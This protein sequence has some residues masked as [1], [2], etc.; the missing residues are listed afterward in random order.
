MGQDKYLEKSLAN[1]T[2]HAQIIQACVEKTALT[3]DFQLILG[4]LFE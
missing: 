3:G 4:M 2:V 1:A